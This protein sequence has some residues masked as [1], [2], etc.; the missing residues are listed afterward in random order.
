MPL[1]QKAVQHSEQVEFEMDLWRGLS[2]G[3]I[4]INRRKS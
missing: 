2:I 1:K 3:K 4:E